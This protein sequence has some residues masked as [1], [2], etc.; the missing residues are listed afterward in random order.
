MAK[1]II[2]N[3]GDVNMAKDDMATPLH[4]AARLGH[5]GVA[6]LLVEFGADM[7]RA[8]NEGNTPRQYL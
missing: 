8:D 4:R 1:L 5:R 6:Q 3:G 2:Q 7:D